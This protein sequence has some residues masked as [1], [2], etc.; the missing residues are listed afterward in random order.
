MYFTF[1]KVNECCDK[2]LKVMEENYNPSGLTMNITDLANACQTQSKQ[3]VDNQFIN[4]TSFMLRAIV[5]GGDKVTKALK[6]KKEKTGK[7]L[8]DP[9][10]YSDTQF[11]SQ[12]AYLNV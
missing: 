4:A 12:T 5:G 6:P 10:K 11:F 7:P 1:V 2:M 9:K 8:W 3:E